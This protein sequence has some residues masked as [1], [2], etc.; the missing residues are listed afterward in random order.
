[1]GDGGHCPL[2]PKSASWD[3]PVV[4]GYLNLE[5]D[6]VGVCIMG[7]DIAIREGDTAPNWSYDVKVGDAVLGRA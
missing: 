5:E 3:L 2:V 1:M 6:N 4:L 7:S